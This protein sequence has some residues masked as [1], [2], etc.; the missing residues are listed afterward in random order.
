MNMIEFSDDASN[1]EGRQ[2]P[3]ST[4]SIPGIAW[5]DA[6][7]V[8]FET[9]GISQVLR[10]TLLNMRLLLTLLIRDETMLSGSISTLKS[11]CR[12][13]DFH[14]MQEFIGFSQYII[15]IADL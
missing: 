6:H 15:Y 2:I 8:F 14:Q 9:S 1:S 12:S 11:P 13:D 10:P 4:A 3:Q 5:I 7:G